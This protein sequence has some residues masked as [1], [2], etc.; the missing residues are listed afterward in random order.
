[1]T[2]PTNSVAPPAPVQSSPA[3]AGIGFRRWFTGITEWIAGL[4]PTGATVYDTGW[5][6]LDPVTNIVYGEQPGVRRIGRTLYFRGQAINGASQPEI[7]FPAGVTTVGSVPASVLAGISATDSGRAI[8]AQ[9]PSG[10]PYPTS[11]WIT[12][13]TIQIYQPA[14]TSSRALLSGFSGL[15]VT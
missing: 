15:P 7:A 12:G 9:T 4:T 8:T 1:M 3:V 2:L 13:R 14:A 11:A 10:V 6:P 5:I